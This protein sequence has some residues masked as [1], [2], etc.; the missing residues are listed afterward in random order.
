MTPG[1][2]GDAG[3]PIIGAGRANIQSACTAA[4]SQSAVTDRSPV[5]VSVSRLSDRLAQLDNELGMLIARLGPVSRSEKS[6]GETSPREEGECPLSDVLN[7]SVD[8][9][10]F[11]IARISGARARLCI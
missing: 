6:S 11:L 8:R 4:M 9:I 3:G 1:Y 7:G 10:E 2:F 5:E